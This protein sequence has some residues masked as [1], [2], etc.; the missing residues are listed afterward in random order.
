MRER[1]RIRAGMPP[2]ATCRVRGT[3]DRPIRC[4]SLECAIVFDEAHRMP[5][6]AAYFEHYHWLRTYVSLDRNAPTLRRVEHPF[7]GKVIAV[8]RVVGL[9]DRYARVG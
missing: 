1:R 5:I 6:R 8:P 4:Q 7:T 2:A 3:A 9:H